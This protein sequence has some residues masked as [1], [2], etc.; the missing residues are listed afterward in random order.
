MEETVMQ[1]KDMFRK[2]IDRE[3]QGVIIVGQGEETNVAQEL[4]EYVV[5]RELQR[6]F[7]DFF[8]AY[9]K[10]IQG[11]TPKMGVWISGF[12]GSGK[13]H[14]LKILSYLLQNKQVGDKHAIDYFIEDQ[15]I[16]NQMVLA[17]MQ[18]A[19]N[20]PSDVIL[21]NIDSKSDSNG[22]ENKDAIVNVF[23]KVFNEMQGFCGSMPHLADLERRLSEEGRF[24]EFKEKFEE[25]YA[26][27]TVEQKQK[28]VNNWYDSI[29]ASLKDDERVYIE[30]TDIHEWFL[31]NAERYDNI[32]I[33][34]SKME[35]AIF[36]KL[37][38]HFIIMTGSMAEGTQDRV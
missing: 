34:K 21:F 35:N 8:A 3:I 24:E 28:I 17:D 18:L 22:K 13:S 23:L 9:K 36:E 26:D 20:T 6:H 33:L 27:L 4:E 37:T 11:T 16:T 32:R 12:F 29:M 31:K 19:A 15:K 5:T 7:A 38:D 10:G 1:I 25:E 2:K 30:T 14:F